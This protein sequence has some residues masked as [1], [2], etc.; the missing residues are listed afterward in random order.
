MLPLSMQHFAVLAP[1]F[2]SHISALEALASQLIERGHAVTWFHQADARTFLVN[3]RISFCALGNQSHPA[4][5]LTAMLKR[6]PDPVD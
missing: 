2:S 5:S 4:G 6:A 1:P 3:Q